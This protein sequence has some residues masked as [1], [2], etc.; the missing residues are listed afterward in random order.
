MNSMR[1]AVLFL[2]TPILTIAQSFDYQI[3]AP[4]KVFDANEK[5][6][7]FHDNSVIAVKQDGGTTL[8]QKFDVNTLKETSR[9]EYAD[10]GD[11]FQYESINRFDDKLYLFYSVY[12][13]PN[14]TEQLFA[15]EIDMTSGTFTGKGRKIVTVKSKVTNFFAG[16]PLISGDEG[17]QASGL[18]FMKF[19]VQDKFNVQTSFDK[20]KIL[21]QYRKKPTEKNDDLNK[22][23]I[24]ICVFDRNLNEISSDEIE[25]PYTEAKMNNL[26]YTIDSKGNKYILTL[27][28]E[29]DKQKLRVG[30]EISYHL[31]VIRIP[32]NSTTLDL[33]PIKLKE[34]Y[35]NDITVF[36]D[37]DDNMICAGF[38]AR[39]KQ[40]LNADGVVM[41]K[42][43][44]EGDLFDMHTYEIPVEVLNMYAKQREQERN[45]K[46]DSKDKAEFQHL[47]M[48][49][50]DAFDDGSILLTG[51]QYYI[52]RTTTQTS[53]GSKT[54]YTPYYNHILAVKIGPD[55]NLSWMKKLG[56][57]QKGKNYSS[58]MAVRQGGCSYN[59]FKS[60]NKH[61]F[62]FL[63]NVNN[64]DLS[65]DERPKYHQD[66]AG[67]F[68]TAYVL[69]DDKG[70]ISKE[71]LFDMRDVKGI[72]VFQFH[73]NRIVHISDNEF[74][75]E[76]YKKK[77]ED[78]LIK[79]TVKV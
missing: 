10:H 49:E 72:E 27:I 30:G 77:K 22:D 35:I 76:V 18:G 6:Y 36:N 13:K 43:R 41:F 37:K 33:V 2:F 66:G 78:M 51:E 53:N 61:Y 15:R 75:V 71:N 3:S 69:T 79:V 5:E 9:K 31:E 21:V 59:Y 8:I 32:V 14:E 25:M 12:D 1:L 57:R 4:Y 40:G 29:N 58:L 23:V 70:S 62:F 26:D 46:K 54:T 65:L 55:G 38:Y 64:S 63:D 48:R 19:G 60:N 34:G 42:I 56:K 17:G 47:R 7:F 11:G 39:G 68:F 74:I 50:L 28:Y 20:S 73:I 67:G 24:G 16:S 44:P 45:E 52:I